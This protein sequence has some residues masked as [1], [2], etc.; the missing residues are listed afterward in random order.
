MCPQLAAEFP[1]S[2]FCC[3]EEQLDQLQ[4]QVACRSAVPLAVACRRVVAL[5]CSNTSLHPHLHNPPINRFALQIQVASI[6]L[7]GCPACNH[8][9]KH[10]FCLLT[11]SP[12]QASFVNVTA[13]QTA[14]DT[15]A[16]NA[17]AEADYFLAGGW[18]WGG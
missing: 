11:C 13:A 3:T 10:F 18:R 2:S 4:S 12:N 1:D 9:F 16:S 6:F 14:P 5:L 7:V 15:N 17:I 8:N